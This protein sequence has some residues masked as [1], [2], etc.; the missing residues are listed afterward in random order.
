MQLLHNKVEVTAG[1]FFVVDFT[2]LYTVR[3]KSNRLE[4]S[5]EKNCFMFQF[6]TKNINFG[7]E[8]KIS[9]ES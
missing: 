6:S 1:G 9:K 7:D 3:Q 5:A 2:L 4:V 8:Q